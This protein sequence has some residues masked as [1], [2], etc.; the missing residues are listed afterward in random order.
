MT[1]CDSNNN[2]EFCKTRLVIRSFTQKYDIDY[3]ETLLFVLEKIPLE[4]SWYWYP[5]MRWSYIKSNEC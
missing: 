1:K 3:K 4:I 2:C 5:I